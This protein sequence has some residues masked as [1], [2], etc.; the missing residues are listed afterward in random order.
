[1]DEIERL[2]NLEIK[3]YTV[4]QKDYLSRCLQV[5]AHITRKIRNEGSLLEG[6]F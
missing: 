1:L 4:K 5:A 6:D 2:T 3:N